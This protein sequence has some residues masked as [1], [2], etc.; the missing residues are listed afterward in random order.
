[1]LVML[2]KADDVEREDVKTL[3]R[4]EPG[5]KDETKLTKKVKEIPQEH[6]NGDDFEDDELLNFYC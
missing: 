1:M 3:K 5:R 4:D 6:Q 2:T